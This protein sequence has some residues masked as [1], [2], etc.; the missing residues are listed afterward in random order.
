MHP[1]TRSDHHYRT[2]HTGRFLSHQLRT[3]LAQRHLGKALQFT[4]I[5]SA[6]FNLFNFHLCRCLQ[7]CCFTQDQFR[8]VLPGIL[9]IDGKLG[10][11]AGGESS[12]ELATVL[13]ASWYNGVELGIANLDIRDIIIESGFW[14]RVGS[15][16]MV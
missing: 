9:F 3:T 5:Q 15:G 16:G 10:E 1:P 2:D 8:P 4:E 12:S 14:E 11:R 7:S 13:M 6:F